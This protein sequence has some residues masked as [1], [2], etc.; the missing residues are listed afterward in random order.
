MLKYWNLPKFTSVLLVSEFCYIELRRLLVVVDWP[1]NCATVLCDLW[2][3]NLKRQVS[4]YIPGC[5]P[6]TPILLWKM[7]LQHLISTCFTHLFFRAMHTHTT[8]TIITKRTP[9]TDMYGS[10]SGESKTNS[11]SPRTTESRL[12]SESKTFYL[13]NC[14]CFHH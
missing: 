2:Q 6:K 11:K 10:H 12:V 7:Q 13:C 4:T 5:Q 14:F 9:T 3:K 1:G 8:H